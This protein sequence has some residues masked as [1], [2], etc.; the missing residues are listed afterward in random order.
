MAYYNMIGRALILNLWDLSK[1]FDKEVVADVTDSL[2]R[3]GICG[4][5]Y[6][7]WYEFNRKSKIKGKYYK[8]KPVFC[9]F[10]GFLELV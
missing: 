9:F 7:L 5:L 8:I 2:Y 6:R 1:Y 3:A 10:T 4:K